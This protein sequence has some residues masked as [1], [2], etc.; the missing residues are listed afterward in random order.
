MRKKILVFFVTL[1]AF[2]CF[3]L[4][5]SPNFQTNPKPDE[6][7]PNIKKLLVILAH[8]DDEISSAA[9][10]QHL[11]KRGTQ[12]HVV[13]L[14]DGT[15]N[16]QSNLAMCKESSIMECRKRESTNAL[17]FIGAESTL[18]LDLADSKLQSQL[19]TAVP[20]LAQKIS[21]FG[22]DGVLVM[23]PSGL[24]GQS[25]HKAAFQISAKALKYI[26]YTPNQLI[27]TSLPFPLSLFFPT[28]LSEFRAKNLNTIKYSEKVSVLKSRLLKFYPSQLK[29]IQSMLLFIPPEI[30][31]R[32]LKWESFFIFEAKDIQPIL[33]REY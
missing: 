21:S 28:K 14:S 20:L 24:N 13:V 5:I 25:D 11:A 9:M 33:N 3:G 6:S 10:I 7:L 23:E 12:V 1:L 2:L 30:F 32:W 27:L 15:A 22:P 29:T 26:N 17:Q 31:F 8:S 18:F 4:L 19:E 16:P